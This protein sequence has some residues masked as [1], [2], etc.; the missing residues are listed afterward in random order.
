MTE[1][2]TPQAPALPPWVSL[3][4][5]AIRIGPSVAITLGA[6]CYGLGLLIVTTRLATLGV[7]TA[8]FFKTEYVLA[9]A[10]FCALTLCGT[11][12]VYYSFHSVKGAITVW[13][14]D[15]R[16]PARI[17]AV[18]WFVLVLGGGALIFS[19]ALNLLS[20]N[21]FG[22][23]YHFQMWLALSIAIAFFF[24]AK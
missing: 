12:A 5:I 11:A 23:F 16:I 21:N 6:I 14:Q 3:L 8:D 4:R 15:K 17:R 22:D 19:N 13:K 9:G 7:Y 20:T 24:P 1:P 18:L 2:Q 10:T